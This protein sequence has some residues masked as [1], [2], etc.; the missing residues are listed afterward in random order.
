LYE[1]STCDGADDACDGA[2]ACDSPVD[3]V[4]FPAGE[5]SCKSYGN[6]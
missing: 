1:K 5:R 6:N 2:G 3:R 4:Q